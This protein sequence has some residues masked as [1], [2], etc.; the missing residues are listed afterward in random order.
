M[1][2]SLEKKSS[3]TITP[4]GTLASSKL[5]TSEAKVVIEPE[6]ELELDCDFLF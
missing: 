4:K 1:F 2:D 6:L 3:L 5:V